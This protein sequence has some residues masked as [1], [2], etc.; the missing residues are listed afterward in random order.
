MKPTRSASRPQASKRGLRQPKTEHVTSPSHALTPPST[1]RSHSPYQTLEQAPQFLGLPSPQTWPKDYRT[2][3]SET[4]K[5]RIEESNDFLK[6]DTEC[7]DEDSHSCKEGISLSVRSASKANDFSQPGEPP[8]LPSTPTLSVISDAGYQQQKDLKAKQEQE[9]P[10]KYAGDIIVTPST[11]TSPS[12]GGTSPHQQSSR[13]Q[14]ELQAQLMN[15]WEKIKN[16][17]RAGY[18]GNFLPKVKL[19]KLINEDSV[20]CELAARSPS[21]SPSELR[22]VAKAVCVEENVDTGGGKFK[23]RSCRQIFAVLVLIDQSTSIRLFLKEG[24]SDLDLPLIEHCDDVNPNHNMLFR[25]NWD[26]DTQREPLHCTKYWS[27][28]IRRLFCE[29]QWMVLAPFFSLGAYNHVNHYPLKD[30]HLLPFV[31]GE[32]VLSLEPMRSQSGEIVGG[33]SQ[34]FRVW[35]HSDHHGFHH[36]GPD[37]QRGFAIKQLQKMEEDVFRKEVNML[38]KFSGDGSHPHVVSVLATYEQ[39]GRYHLIFHWADG[40]L[41]RYWKNICPTPTFDYDTVLWVAKQLSGLTDGL[42]RFHRHYTD[43][44]HDASHQREDGSHREEEPPQKRTRL[45]DTPP[46]PTQGAGS[47]ESSS[48]PKKEQFGRHGDLKPQNILLFPSP[49]DNRGVLKISDL[50]QAELRSARSKTRWDT[51]DAYTLTYR[52]PETD[53]ERCVIRQSGDI[54]SLGCLF[55]E[56][57]TWMLG[58]MELVVDFE[59]QRLSWDQRLQMKS[60]TFYERENV[61]TLQHVG[62]RLKD[63]VI[64]HIQQLRLHRNCTEYF[65]DVLDLISERMLIIDDSTPSRREECGKIRSRLKKAYEKC[66]NQKLYAVGLQGE[67]DIG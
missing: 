55:L 56:F 12:P 29:D 66:K 35:I 21:E 42:Y 31:R 59:N 17:M 33:Y 46:P 61:D 32:Q 57:V 10:S 4:R 19:D 15:S 63:S 43:D 1:Q 25:G 38:K 40:D 51:K 41:L 7:V 13:T 5:R 22:N 30:Q 36:C 45:N 14:F 53:V 37:A 44:D 18:Q 39:S 64:T 47:S 62:A 58:G 20:F 50:G 28:R 16:P 27:P 49:E 24:V 48:G 65:R 23:T 52:P 8:R 11:P 54:W 9:S 26:G 2:P 34:V 6:A 67:M 60:D 3:P